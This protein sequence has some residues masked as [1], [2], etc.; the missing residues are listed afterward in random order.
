MQQPG[1]QYTAGGKPQKALSPD[2]RYIEQPFLYI[3]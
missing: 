3:A 1:L 2:A